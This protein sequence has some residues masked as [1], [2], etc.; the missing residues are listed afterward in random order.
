MQ[1]V[2][3]AMM[4]NS[5]HHPLEKPERVKDSQAHK[6]EH[7]NVKQGKRLTANVGGKV[8]C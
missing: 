3:K 4:R 1:T 7:Q 8:E 5:K 2:E 6:P